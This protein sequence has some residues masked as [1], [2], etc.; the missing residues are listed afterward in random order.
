MGWPNGEEDEI[1]ISHRSLGNQKSTGWGREAG[2]GAD[3]VV[4]AREA[5]DLDQDA[6]HRMKRRVNSGNS[7]W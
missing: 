6:G 4:Q 7:H 2:E 5:E 1:Y 3:M